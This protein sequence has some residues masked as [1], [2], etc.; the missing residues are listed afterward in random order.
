MRL[1]FRAQRRAIALGSFTPHLFSFN[2]V[3]LAGPELRYH[4]LIVGKS[5]SGKSKLLQHLMQSF[6]AQSLTESPWLG[7]YSP[8]GATVLEPHHDLSF[9]LLTSLVASGFYRRVP[10]A[11]QRVV[12]IDFGADYYAPFNVL[13]G[14]GDSHQKAS[15]A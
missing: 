4:G 10:D 5:G 12:Y 7:R 15:L 8:H 11:Y 2:Q 6:I 14:D 3:K 9:D 1:P 13:A